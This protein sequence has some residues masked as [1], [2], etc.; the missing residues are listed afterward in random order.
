MRVPQHLV[1][2][3]REELRHLIRCD[4]FLPVN[5]ICQRL[6]VSAATARRDL[7]AVEANGHITRTYGGGAGGLQ[8]RLRIA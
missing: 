8:Q 5:V 6:G 1:D 7:V 3:R 4:G 2:R